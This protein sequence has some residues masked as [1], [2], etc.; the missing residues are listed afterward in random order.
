MNEF[1]IKAAE[2]DKNQMHWD[3]SAAISSEIKRIIPLKP[4]YSAMEYGAGTGILSMMLKDDLRDILLI[5]NSGEMI[6]QSEERIRNSGS[7]N[8]RA[9]FF[10]LEHNDLQ[11]ENFDLIYTQM[12]LH[13]V[14]NVQSIFRRFSGLLNPG[15]YLAIADLYEEDGSFHGDGFT[16]HNGFDP[17]K[18]AEELSELGFT[19]ISERKCYVINRKISDN[20]TKLFD[21]FLLTARKE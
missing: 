2:W 20:Q 16:G 3:R 13:H 11:G 8:L 21:V 15:G 4:E 12:V 18:L 17:V 5:D 6:K 10:D 9:R 19:D 7:K 14:T 1:D